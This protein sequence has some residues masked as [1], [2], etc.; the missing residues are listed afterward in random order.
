MWPFGNNKRETRSALVDLLERTR[1][2]IDASEE[3]SWEGLSTAEIGMDLSIAIENL[4]NGKAI[5]R[6]LL[7]MHFAP[8]GPLQEI[9]MMSGWTDEYMSLSERFDKL[10]DAL[11]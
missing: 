7:R 5:D 8:T 1:V 4:T 6:D 9:A 11:R 3:S 2:L 10:I